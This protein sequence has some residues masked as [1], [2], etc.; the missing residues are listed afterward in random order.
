MPYG[1]PA[2][3]PI[4]HDVYLT[5]VGGTQLNVH[6]MPAVGLA[7]GQ[8]AP[9]IL[10]G[11]G[12]VMPGSTNLN[13]T[14]FDGLI[15]DNF[16][17]VGV[18]TLRRAGSNVVTWDPRGEF[19]SGGVLEL[20]SPEY[21]GRNV[22]LDH[23][24]ALH[25][26]RSPPRRSGRSAC[27]HGRPSYGGGIQL[28]TASIDKRVTGGSSGADV[29]LHRDGTESPPLWQLVDDTTGLVLGNVATPIP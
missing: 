12:L 1:L 8:R 25:S 16:G 4:S 13:G 17:F 15:T 14:P 24:L 27:R 9:T 20:N 26:A 10:S 21:E 28:V 2:G 6:F 3:A 11:P 29:Y 23:R 5:S 19:F 7:A 22:G 18:G